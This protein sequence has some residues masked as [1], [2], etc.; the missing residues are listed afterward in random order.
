MVP[1]APPSLLPPISYYIEHWEISSYVLAAGGVGA[2]LL[3]SFSEDIGPCC[4]SPDSAIKL[5]FRVYNGVWCSMMGRRT[6]Y[7]GV[8]TSP[9]AIRVNS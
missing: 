9:S 6:V 8:E 7:C 3:L 2:Q 4:S 1:E 5:Q